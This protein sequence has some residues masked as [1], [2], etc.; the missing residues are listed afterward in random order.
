MPRR[1]NHVCRFGLPRQRDDRGVGKS[2]ASKGC[3]FQHARC[4]FRHWLARRET[5]ELSNLFPQADIVAI[6]CNRE[7]LER[8]RRNIAH[9]PRIK[10][11]DKAINSYTGRCAFYPIDPARTITTWADGNPGASSLF[12]AT[13]DYPVEKYVQNKVEVD[14]IRLDDLCGQFR[15]M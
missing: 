8:C 11:V 9:N 2:P 1:G 6:E 5:V 3:R 4:G 15:S 14:C 13:G 7:T 12:I 10:L